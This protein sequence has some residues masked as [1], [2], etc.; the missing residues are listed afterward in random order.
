LKKRTESGS[1]KISD[2][3]SVS[4]HMITYNHALFIEQ[5]IESILQQKTNVSFEL[6]IGEDCSTDETRRIILGYR[7]KYP[8]II[9]VVMSDKNVGMK[10]NL[11]RTTEACQGK[12]IAFCEGDNYWSCQNKLQKQF[13]YL[14]NHSECGMV[15]ADCNIYY[16]NSKKFAKDFNY[17]NG[18][19]EELN[20]SLERVLWGNFPIWTCTVMVR[21]D[22]YKRITTS[23]SYLYNNEQILQGD[24]QAWAELATVSTV[25]Y[26]PE[27][28]S[29]Y[30]VLDESASR[31]RD[32]VKYLLFHKS[33]FETKMYLSKK[34]SLPEKWQKTAE[35]SWCDT[36]LRLAFF[37][38]NACLAQEVKNVKKHLSVSE[39]LR[40]YGAQYSLIHYS[41]R[42]V[43]FLLSKVRKQRQKMF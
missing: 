35:S 32:N 26:V 25:T 15:S 33:I 29:T 8:K 31:S 30:R 36:S 18:F 4:V 27:T 39:L 37:Q 34:Y 22:L 3:L 10:K 20:F 23:D 38:K 5:A 1:T 17:N 13:E 14:E 24:L 12:Y 21:S 28:F 7:D 40:Y 6:V 42:F 2:V 9:K 43:S 16:E 41:Y 11:L 19:R